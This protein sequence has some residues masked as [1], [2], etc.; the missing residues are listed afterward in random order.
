MNDLHFLRPYFFYLFIPLVLGLILFL[1]KKNRSCWDKICSKDLLPYVIVKKT[2]KNL[3]FAF[4]MFALFSW[5]ITAM[6]GPSWQ[7]SFQP[8]FKPRDGLVIALDLSD[9]MN[10]ED[11][12][13]SRLKRAIYKINDILEQR[14]GSQTALLVFSANPF[15]V[16]PLTDDHATI[17]S[18]LTAL[19]TSIMPSKGH[20]VAKALQK[21]SELLSQ[22]GVVNGSILLI[23]SQ[24]SDD[25]LNK[26]LDLIQKLN[27]KLSILG[28]GTENST[29]ILNPMGGFM[30]DAKGGILTT[31]LPVENLKK[32][33]N[34]NGLYLDLKIDDSDVLLLAKEFNNQSNIT[35]DE[36]KMGAKK[37]Q[38]Q[39]Y[40]LVLIALPFI[41]L[42]FRRG[43]LLSLIFI[44]QIC[45]GSLFESND[46]KAE[47][48]FCQEEYSEACP[49][50]E[51]PDWKACAHYKL[52]EYEAASALFKEN[53]S[54]DGLYNYGT[55]RAKLGDFEEALNAYSKVLEINP[56]HEDALYNK[57]LIEEQKSKDEKPNQDNQDKKD[58][59]KEND[60]NQ[61][62]Q[63]KP[64]QENQKKSENQDNPKDKNNQKASENEDKQNP[65]KDQ[66]KNEENE[67]NEQ[68]D[69]LEEPEESDQK[70][71]E[72]TE[73]P[74][75]TKED[76]QKKM[77]DRLLDRIKDDPGGLLRRKFLQ[78]Y[79][80][81]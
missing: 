80:R 3:S 62:E 78:Q 2:T 29:P 72:K 50:F 57:K 22:A 67:D 33:A 23:T 70:P 18:Q 34:G 19:D 31:K 21:A 39:G 9:A 13:P 44:P 1:T 74:C 75:E 6:A 4:F 73:E 24:L 20:N 36:S 51:N 46:E 41:S 64:D 79:R 8:F 55:A 38:D 52:E 28:V 49:L 40:L 10:A 60:P 26:S 81:Q 58:K 35:K 11:I 65:D 15:M 47:K 69:D 14:R 27:F 48:L 5:L 12:K 71:D 42:L 77:D 30:K 43:V 59:N 54:V 66:Q 37:W 32:L 7:E 16:T 53:D 61:S 76:A 17:Q 45:F 56:E 63:N 68:K 25:D